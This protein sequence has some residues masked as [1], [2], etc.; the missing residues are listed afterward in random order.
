MS[1]DY[2]KVIPTAIPMKRAP[3]KTHRDPYNCIPATYT[4]NIV[5]DSPKT[6]QLF[7]EKIAADRK[8]L[9]LD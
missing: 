3:A 4:E 9:G 7:K 1:F 8:R 6:S 5:A 2:E